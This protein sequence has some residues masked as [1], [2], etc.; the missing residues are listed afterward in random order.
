MIFLNVPFA[1]KTEHPLDEI[2]RRFRFKQDIG[3]RLTLEPATAT[4]FNFRID[5]PHPLVRFTMTRISETLTA[6][7]K[8]QTI[9]EE[10]ATP[11][12]ANLSP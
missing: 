3:Q 12:V 6:H 1:F 9:V 2:Q 4:V 5:V 11:Y 8:T 10:T 7:G